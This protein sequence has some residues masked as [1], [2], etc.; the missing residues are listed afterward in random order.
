MVQSKRHWN[1]TAVEKEK[2]K[3]GGKYRKRLQH[4][5]QAF[6]FSD[7][8]LKAKLQ[9]YTAVFVCICK[10]KKIYLTT[11]LNT[12]NTRLLKTLQLLQWVQLLLAFK[13]GGL[14]LWKWKRMW[15]RIQTHQ[16]PVFYTKILNPILYFNCQASAM[17]EYLFRATM[18]FHAVLSPILKTLQNIYKMGREENLNYIET[19][20]PGEAL[21]HWGIQ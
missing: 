15:P 5:K 8:E 16:L 6:F 3:K 2:K 14:S 1:W 4:T 11:F 13:S 17:W 18:S 10:D 7:E 19:M 9:E 21:Y 20:R 12:C